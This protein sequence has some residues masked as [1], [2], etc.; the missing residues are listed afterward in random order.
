MQGILGGFALFAVLYIIFSFERKK[1]IDHVVLNA[2]AK[3][4]CWSRSI[5]YRD[6]L[7]E[8]RNRLVVTDIYGDVSELA[9]CNEVKM[10]AVN[11]LGYTSGISK[12]HRRAIDPTTEID[13]LNR[14]SELE[15]YCIIDEI[16]ADRTTSKAVC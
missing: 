16:A 7:I 2:K 11:K 1:G 12:A 5:E 15:I 6:V 3:E 4:Y 10:F 13:L 14:L 8:Q 9:W